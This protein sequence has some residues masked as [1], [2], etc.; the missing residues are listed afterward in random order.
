MRERAYVF[1]RSPIVSRDCQGC[2]PLSRPRNFASLSAMRLLIAV[3]QFLLCS[4]SAAAQQLMRPDVMGRSVALSS[5]HQ[6]ATAAGAAVLLRGGNAVDAAI[7]MAGVLAVVRP[8][9]NGVGGDLFMLYREA[10]SGRVFGLNGSGGAGSGA[11]PQAFAARG[12]TRVPGTGILSV[13]VPG[14]VRAWEDALSRFGTTTLQQALAPA[15]GYAEGGFPV[16]TRLSLDFAGEIEK[17]SNDP[18]LARTYLANGS[19]PLPG[20]LLV[21]KDLAAAK[22]VGLKTAYVPRP[23][24]YGAAG[25]LS[26]HN[27]AFDFT[28]VDFLDLAKQLGA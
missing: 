5:D 15:I 25:K 8:H 16:S 21:Q 14:A 24:E 1:A 23:L 9:M 11:V 10:K 19:A 20:T 7:A 17:I 27:E 28:A 18:E 12:L 4:L 2:G 3:A 22:R 13:S 6:L 26:P